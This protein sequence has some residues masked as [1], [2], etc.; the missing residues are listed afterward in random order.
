MTTLLPPRRI[1]GSTGLEVSSICIGTSPLASMSLLYG[2]SVSEGRA[3]ET[4][5]SVFNSPFNFIDTSNDYGADGAA[6]RRIGLALR[7]H[8]GLPSGMVLATKVDPDP[9][10]G[11]F[12]GRRVRRSLEESMERLG[13]D[14]I[15]LLHLHD[16]ER[17]SFADA[18][19]PGGPV[20][21][22]VQ[23]KDEGLVDHLGVAGG[24]VALMQQYVDTGAFEVVLTHNR[25]TLLDRSAS[26]LFRDAHERG[27]GVLNAAPY[28]G[29]MLAKGP[30]RQ[31]RYAYGLGD[32][33]IGS[34]AAAMESVLSRAGVPLAAA[35]LQF[36]LR[37]PFVHSTV[38]GVSTP[39][40]VRQTAE[41]ATIDIPEELWDE[42]EQLTPRSDL[43]LDPA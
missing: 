22:L 29:G 2:Y 38:V 36:S 17:M 39:E 30:D 34:T 8:G 18:I 35:A 16:P 24:S 23:L 42:L 4:V 3:V 26:R 20:E 31:Q 25:Y 41:L 19:A 15:Q 11:D 21:A 14:H 43:W 32:E 12:S 37:A 10:T 40:R 7:S 9:A 1:L 13:L 5:E 6:E 27:M 33:S 28:G